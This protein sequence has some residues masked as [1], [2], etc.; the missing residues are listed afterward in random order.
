MLEKAAKYEL[1]SQF[2]KYTNP[3]LHIHY[4]LTHLNSMNKAFQLKSHFPDSLQ[5]NMSEAKIRI[6]HAS[7]DTPNI[8]FYVNSNCFSKEVQYKKITE[9]LLL[10]KGKHQIDLFPTDNKGSSLLSKEITI[11]PGKS[12]TVA[13]IGK[14]KNL[15]LAPYL[16]QP[17][18]PPEEAKIRFLHLS[19]DVPQLDIAVKNRDIVFPNI[20]YKKVTDY[21]GLTPMT[22]DLEVRKAGT[23]NVILPM[24]K[25][26]FLSNQAYTIVLVGF[27]KEK[28]EIEALFI[29]D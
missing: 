16:N 24:P 10:P 7:P 14:V 29:K 21:L 15:C 19:P 12:Y 20:S 9:Y 5:N 17:E 4:Y 18:V 8:D 27:I 23:K 11:E 26:K 13:I 22:I 25:S 6:L 1:L 2:Y 3:S 28:L